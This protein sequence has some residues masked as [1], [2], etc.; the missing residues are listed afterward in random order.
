M[1]GGI[2]T[3]ADGGQAEGEVWLVHYTNTG[4]AVAGQSHSGQSTCLGFFGTIIIS[5]ATVLVCFG[6]VQ[7]VQVLVCTFR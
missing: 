6:Y 1:L 5:A 2:Y 3:G 7:R 4:T